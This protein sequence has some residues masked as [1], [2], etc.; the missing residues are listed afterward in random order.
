MARE[1]KEPDLLVPATE[2]IH[3][4]ECFRE[5]HLISNEGEYGTTSEMYNDLRERAQKRYDEFKRK[6][7]NN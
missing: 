7:Y 6:T 2:I 4:V 5:L 1:I 3:L